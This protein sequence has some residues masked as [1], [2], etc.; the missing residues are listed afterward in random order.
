MEENLRQQFENTFTTCRR[1]PRICEKT[2]KETPMTVRKQFS[3][4]RKKKLEQNNTLLM[5]ETLGIGGSPEGM[6]LKINKQ[7]H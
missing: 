5:S 4:E 3:T 2:A 6:L 1:S 7:M